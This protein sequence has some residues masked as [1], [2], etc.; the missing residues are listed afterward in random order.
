LGVADER[1]VDG[2]GPHRLGKQPGAEGLA[3]PRVDGDAEQVE[4]DLDR[5]DDLERGEQADAA[6]VERRVREPVA[7]RQLPP[8]ALGASTRADLARAGEIS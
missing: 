1:A 5:L 8:A 3:R 6:V 7:G 4:A 2:L